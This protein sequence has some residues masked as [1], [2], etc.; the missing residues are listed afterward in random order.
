MT[1]LLVDTFVYIPIIPSMLR[2]YN[3]ICKSTIMLFE[4][5]ILQQGSD[6]Y[7]HKTTYMLI[8]FKIQ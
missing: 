1:V 2:V 8:S 5:I 4:L 7:L 6:M 3:K